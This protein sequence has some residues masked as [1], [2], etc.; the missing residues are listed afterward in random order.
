MADYIYAHTLK[1]PEYAPSRFD[2]VGDFQPNGFDVIGGYAKRLAVGEIYGS[3]EYSVSEEDLLDIDIDEGGAA[4]I[5][6]NADRHYRSKS[7]ST[8]EDGLREIFGFSNKPR[9]KY[10][11]KPIKIGTKKAPAKLKL[12]KLKKTKTPKKKRGGDEKPA[13][14]HPSRM[15]DGDAFTILPEDDDIT[16]DL[17]EEGNDVVNDD[18]NDNVNDE[19]EDESEDELAVYVADEDSESESEDEA[20]DDLGVDST[21][22]LTDQSLGALTPIPI[23]DDYEVARE[24]DGW[25]Y[26]GGVDARAGETDDVHDNI[27][28][29][30][31]EGELN[32]EPKKESNE[33]KNDESILDDL[34]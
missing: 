20:G 28:E 13:D 11:G 2:I 17:L 25:D 26:A 3:G 16:G 8:V 12:K 32:D 6:G 4:V 29:D 22:I 31:L 21:N 19:S 27:G 30:E 23:L 7:A 15:G 14:G 10:D 18:V 5:I 34:Q 24:I 33:E 1:A 9:I